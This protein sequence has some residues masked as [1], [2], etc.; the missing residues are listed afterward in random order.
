[1]RGSRRWRRSTIGF[2]GQKPEPKITAKVAVRRSNG[3]DHHQLHQ[4]LHGHFA[5]P[6]WAMPATS[7]SSESGV[8]DLCSN[9]PQLDNEPPMPPKSPLGRSPLAQQ[10]R[11][12][13]QQPQQRNRM[14]QVS[15][16]LP[17]AVSVIYGPLAAL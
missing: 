8:S 12:I 2:V 11:E 5:T 4:C 7:H 10:P 1:M 15:S 6:S 9:S 13:H 3:H 17:A 14:P 16:P